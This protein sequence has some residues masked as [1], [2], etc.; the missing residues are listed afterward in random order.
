[1]ENLSDELLF[2]HTGIS[3]EDL[4]TLRAVERQLPLIAALENADIFLDIPVEEDTALVAAHERPSERMSM[5]EKRIVGEYAYRENEPA[6]FHAA[7]MGVP[8]C[9]IKA[10]TQERRTVRQN[11]APVFNDAGRVI[12]VLIREKDISGDL[13]KE[14]K[15][16][17]LAKAAGENVPMYGG[18]REQE[19]AGSTALREMHHRIKNSLQLIASM[20]NLA[21]RTKDDPETRA[22][23][24][25]SVARVLSIASI[26]DIL[27][28][29]KG[30]LT[31]VSATALFE[32]LRRNLAALT[33]P[34]KHIVLTVS[35]EDAALDADTA[36]AVAVVVTEL[37]TNALLHAFEGRDGGTV[38]VGFTKGL[39]YHTVRVTDDGT[40]FEPETAG[41]ERLG[42]NIVRSTIHDKLKGRMHIVSG[43]N[44]T[45][46]SFDF[47]TE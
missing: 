45:K 31:N 6:V 43:P 39:L 37:V 4:A 36:T 33:P 40:G 34:G 26:H 14:R 30:A 7:H 28:N 19:D 32:Q 13:A 27:C 2:R 25:E 44:G 3:P 12:A 8:V 35:A 5:Y 17:E 41:Q 18:V 42:L 20:L 24:K 38:S 22:V 15:Y 10:L 29:G 9:D 47:K 23:L 16:E 46:V 21:A 1:M 11:A